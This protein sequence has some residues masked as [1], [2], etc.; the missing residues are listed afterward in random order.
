M[1]TKLGKDIQKGDVIFLEGGEESRV[2]GT[3]KGFSRGS[4]RIDHTAGWTQVG[5]TDLIEVKE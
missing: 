5:Q 3:G 2:K 1:K 4:I